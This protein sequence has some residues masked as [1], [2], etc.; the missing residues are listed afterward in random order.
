MTELTENCKH[1]QYV[2]LELDFGNPIQPTIWADGE[3]ELFDGQWRLIKSHIQ[4]YL[5]TMHGDEL[6]P[7]IRSEKP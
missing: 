2:I 4:S 7:K 1:S 5:I 3:K 6:L